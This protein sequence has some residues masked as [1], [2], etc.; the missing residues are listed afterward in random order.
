MS[1]SF[2][3]ALKG[4]ADWEFLPKNKRISYAAKG[5]L[6]RWGFASKSEDCQG[7]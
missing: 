4:T 7:K 3:F 5:C 1:G 2:L 6:D